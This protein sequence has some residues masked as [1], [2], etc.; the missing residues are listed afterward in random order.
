MYAF[1]IISLKIAISRLRRTPTNSRDQHSYS[2][3]VRELYPDLDKAH[4]NRIRTTIY[5]VA[6]KGYNPKSSEL[7]SLLGLCNYENIEVCPIHNMV[8]KAACP[9]MAT[10]PLPKKKKAPR[11]NIRLRPLQIRCSE[12]QYKRILS[13]NTTRRAIVLL[14]G[15]KNDD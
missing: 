9:D 7:R 3:I 15:I 2:D 6:K 8:H 5:H 14:K 12:Y 13:L 11:P 4:F 10:K 1:D